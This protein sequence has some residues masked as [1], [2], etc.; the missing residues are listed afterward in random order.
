MYEAKQNK[1]KVSRRIDSFKKRTDSNA[2]FLPKKTL[3]LTTAHAK[4]DVSYIYKDNKKTV[5]KEADGESGKEHVEAVRVEY[6]RTWTAGER[7]GGKSL[8]RLVHSWSHIGLANIPFDCMEGVLHIF[9]ILDDDRTRDIAG[10]PGI[11]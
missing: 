4:V 5:T 11:I 7:A 1:E 9:A 3:Q 10:R 2:C 8:E 6:H